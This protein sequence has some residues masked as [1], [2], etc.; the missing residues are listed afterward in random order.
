MCFFEG[1]GKDSYAM[2]IMTKIF[3]YNSYR[4]VIFVADTIFCI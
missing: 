1:A 3:P 2:S 4:L